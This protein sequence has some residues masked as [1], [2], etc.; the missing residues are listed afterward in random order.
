M[1]MMTLSLVCA[2]DPRLKQPSRAV[3]ASEFGHDLD[4]LMDAMIATMQVEEGAGLA[5]VQVG[6]MRRIVI[7]VLNGTPVKMVNPVL[8][9]KSKTVQVDTEGCL[10]FPNR[11]VKRARSRQ[12]TVTFQNPLTG[13]QV[14]RTVFGFEARAVQHELDHLDGKTIL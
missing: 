4:S 8:T 13:E 3:D 7:V 5:G 14:T 12:V 10:S 6:E 9:A 2:P 11:K 1:G